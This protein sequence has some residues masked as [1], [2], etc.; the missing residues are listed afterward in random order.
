M[1]FDGCFVKS[2]Y[3]YSG[4]NRQY[5]LYIFPLFIFSGA[6]FREIRSIVA[7]QPVLHEQETAF[8]KKYMSTLTQ[9]GISMCHSSL[10]KFIRTLPHKAIL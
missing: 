7:R 10:G 3:F 8:H 4:N 6:N 5:T 2:F 9:G 1:E